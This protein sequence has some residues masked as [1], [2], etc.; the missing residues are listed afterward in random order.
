MGNSHLSGFA[1]QITQISFFFH[2]KCSLIFE[3]G[4]ATPKGQ[5]H[6]ATID[7]SVPFASI[8]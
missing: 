2:V 4:N 7:V 6:R 8:K 5:L 1:I 3:I